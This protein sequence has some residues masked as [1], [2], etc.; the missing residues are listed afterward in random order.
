M[1]TT[2]SVVNFAVSLLP[3]LLF[4][5]VFFSLDSYKLIH[6]RSIIIA[7]AAGCGAAL[8]A[9]AV[10]VGVVR[11]FVLE[12]RFFPLYVAPFIEEFCKAS[13]LYVLL[14]KAKIGFLVDA[15]IY[16]FAIGAGF[17]LVENIYYLGALETENILVWIVRGLGTAIMHGGVTAI[18]AVVTKYFS[19][20][21]ES[22]TLQSVIPG[23]L[24][25]VAIHS[26]FNHAFFPPVI[27]TFVVLLFFP[28]VFYFIFQRSQHATKRWLREGMDSDI[29]MLEVIL[30]GNIG[31]SHIGTYLQS[32]Q[33]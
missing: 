15:A 20:L 12:G 33:T 32:I 26:V 2:H 8:L 10:N 6:P 28:L 5:Y 31:G 25:A 13:Y 1:L 27:M 30:S 22:V 3:V 4:L 21:H 23:F 17:A 18:F 9:F 7:I 11:V 14:R 24:L 29:E 16:G 19:D